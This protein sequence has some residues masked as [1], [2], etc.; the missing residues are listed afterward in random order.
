[1]Y[2]KR[3]RSLPLRLMKHRRNN[4]N[5]YSLSVR[6]TRVKIFQYL[7]KSIL[8][9][10]FVS[11]YYYHAT[12]VHRSAWFHKSIFHPNFEQYRCVLYT[13]CNNTIIRET[14]KFIMDK[15]TI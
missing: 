5:I 2:T 12:Q 6:N 10:R 1:V 14:L 15:K 3:V 9:Q 7:K 11:Y 13:K 8:R 4:E